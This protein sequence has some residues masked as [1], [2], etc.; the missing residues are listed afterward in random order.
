M[1]QSAT[2]SGVV[3]WGSPEYGQLGIG[4]PNPTEDKASPP[5]LVE[6]LRN[7]AVR[8][9]ACGGHHSAAVGESGEVYVWG[10]GRRGQ[11]GT[12]DTK[13][14]IL[15]KAIRSLQSKAI[16][17]VA[18]GEHHSAAVT[19]SGVLYTWGLPRNGRLGH[20]REEGEM[21]L[22]PKVVEALSGQQVVQVSCGDFHT[23]CLVNATAAQQTSAT[24]AAAG[25]TPQPTSVYTWGMGLSGRLGHGDET[26]RYVPTSVEGLAVVQV[27]QVCCGGHHTAAVT[28][29]GQMYTWGGGAF[30]KLGHGSRLAV[31]TPRA[32]AFF[33]GPVG[34]GPSSSIRGRRVVQASLGA[35]HS[36]AVTS[37]GEVFTWGQ[38]GRLG[39][40]WGASGSTS[41][42]GTEQDA[43]MPRQV[44]ALAGIFV[45]MVSC[46]HSQTAVVTETGDVWAW[47][48]TRVLG[49]ADLS[50]APNSPSCVKALTGKA[51]IQVCCGSS[52][53]IALSDF[54]RL[55]SRLP[56]NLQPPAA[57][58]A[59]THQ[60]SP[61][62]AGGGI[63][64]PGATLRP[65]PPAPGSSLSLSMPTRP[66]FTT[67]QTITEP[68]SIE[69]GSE[70][71]AEPASGPGLPGSVGKTLEMGLGGLEA[72]R[73]LPTTAAAAAQ[74]QQ[75]PSGLRQLAYLSAELKAYQDQTI[76]L[77]KALHETNRRLE[78]SQD[79]NS[80]LKSELHALRQTNTETAEQIDGLRQNFVQRIR[81]IERRHSEKEARWKATFQRLRSQLDNTFQPGLTDDTHTLP[82]PAA[83]LVDS[84]THTHGVEVSVAA[85]GGGASGSGGGGVAAGG[86]EEARS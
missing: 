16:R 38:A 50:V 10:G 73:E 20:G 30:G 17:Q 54:K 45:V 60:P 25:G 70:G 80:L 83:P 19:E 77:A 29:S 76:R 22:V 37:K 9:V 18:C 82:L 79:E 47:G 24:A 63:T 4:N 61:P 6:A 78:Q 51:I 66:S 68:S 34:G 39:H 3:V 75:P 57:L 7:I 58:T 23:A 40:G 35:H 33:S 72:G 5:R 69:V 43:M 71:A 56:P 27:T 81:E 26:D 12:G 55:A 8:S 84:H 32:V 31:M 52:H 64:A 41:G 48:T 46:G 74:P 11:L 86:A 14:V 85:S 59:P 28:E 67:D 42:V 21:L 53:T 62:A 15:P 36:A 13:D 2:K 44:A 1:G 65:P 49:H